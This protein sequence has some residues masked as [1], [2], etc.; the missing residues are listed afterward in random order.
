M[1]AREEREIACHFD[2]LIGMQMCYP[3]VRGHSG[4]HQ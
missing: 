4:V 2:V 3:Q 1:G